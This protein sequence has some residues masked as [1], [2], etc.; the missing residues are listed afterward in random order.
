MT[1]VDTPAAAIA[2]VEDAIAAWIEAATEMGR[3][4]PRPPPRAATS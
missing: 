3:P 2:R 1:D 4:I